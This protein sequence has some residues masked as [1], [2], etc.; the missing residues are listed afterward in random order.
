MREEED[1]MVGGN[2]K[3]GVSLWKEI[4]KRCEQTLGTTLTPSGR[5]E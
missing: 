3:A 4:V 2:V 1:C 5:R